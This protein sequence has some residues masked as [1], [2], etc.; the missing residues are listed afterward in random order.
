MRTRG[1]PS[2]GNSEVCQGFLEVVGPVD[3][4]NPGVMRKGSRE[5]GNVSL[6]SRS[7]REYENTR[8]N[9]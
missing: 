9:R 7:A 3:A 8:L 4:F 6:E 2:K 5:K 1:R